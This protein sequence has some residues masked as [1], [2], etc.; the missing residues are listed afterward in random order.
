MQTFERF[1]VIIVS[2]ML[3]SYLAAQTPTIEKPQAVMIDEFYPPTIAGIQAY[4]GP[5]LKISGILIVI[6]LGDQKPLHLKL[7]GLSTAYNVQ[8]RATCI[9]VY[10]S[11]TTYIG[12]CYTQTTI[13]EA[14]TYNIIITIIAP[15][16]QQQSVTPG[17]YRAML[18][19]P[20]T[21]AQQCGGQNAVYINTTE[22][23]KADQNACVSI[24]LVQAEYVGIGGGYG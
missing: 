18:S 23:L 3:T 6:R 14:H 1:L 15:I 13:I 16:F 5:T 12:P 20:Q 8:T 21:L 10:H 11:D 22:L 2:L 24:Q 4:F 19:A 7:Q 9:T 17:Y